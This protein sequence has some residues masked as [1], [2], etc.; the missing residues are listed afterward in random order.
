MAKPSEQVVPLGV[1]DLHRTGHGV[2]DALR[3]AGQGSPLIR[4]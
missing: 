3:D 4:V 1:V 2:Q